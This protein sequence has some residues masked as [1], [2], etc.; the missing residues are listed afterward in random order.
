MTSR[1]SVLS[2]KSISKYYT[3]GKDVVKALNNINL[4]ITRGEI[5]SVVGPSGSGK[6]TLLYVL[7]GLT[8][9]SEGSIFINELSLSK[10]QQS[11]RA[12]F[13]RDNI[14]FVFQDWQLLASLNAYENVLLP[15]MLKGA[16]SITSEM[17]EEVL[18]YFE[19]F[20]LLDR[21]HHYPS[22][23]SGGEQQRIAIIRALIKKPSIVF[24][25]EPT[26]S[27]D[28]A[29][30]DIL[31]SSIHKAIHQEKCTF[32]IVS[33][34]SKMLSISNHSYRI[35]YGKLKQLF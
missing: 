15:L 16:R 20:Q 29:A 23:L 6:S 33:H 31:T 22:E 13:I 3:K 32:I 2:C 12:A 35:E 28:A 4:E 10:M 17:K 8:P 18:K 19:M 26:G 21:T 25:D 34:D 5:S 7:S 24:F 9:P 11:Q 27:L 1:D 30:A 14:G